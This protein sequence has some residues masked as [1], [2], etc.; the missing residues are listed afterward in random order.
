MKRRLVSFAL[1]CIMLL[2]PLILS[3]CGGETIPVDPPAKVYTIYTICGE[4][5]TQESIREVE[6]ALNR[7]TFYQLGYNVKLIMVTEDEYD[8]LIEQTLADVKA[9]EEAKKNKGKGKNSSEE[10]SDKGTSSNESSAV[11]TG[12]DYIALLENGEDYVLPNPRLDIFLVKGYDKYIDLVTRNLLAPLDDKLDSDAKLIKDY[13]F[14]SFLEAAKVTNSKG[15]R[16][17]YGIP[18][19]KGIGQYDYI[20][21]DKEY[22]DKYEID[23]DTMTNLWDLEYYLKIITENEPEVVPLGN[24]FDDPAVSY[25]FDDGFTAYI[26][27]GVT[28][29]STYTD[30]SVLDYFTLISRYRTMGYLQDA[31]DNRRW[32]VKFVR[33]TFEDI[34]KLE[35]ETGREYDYTIHSYPVATNEDLLA[36]LFCISA[37][38]VSSDLTAAAEIL[39]FI[40]TNV[41]AANLLLHGVQG[42]H[43]D[44]D[45]KNQVVRKANT[46]NME[47]SHTGNAFITYTYKGENPEKWQKLMIQNTDSLKTKELSASLGFAYYPVGIK[48]PNDANQI[49]YE[50]N[51]VN[52]IKDHT[53]KFYPKLING[54]LLNVSWQTIV[55]T[56]GPVVTE[57][58]TA[59][60]TARYKAELN[61]IV[62]AEKGEKYAKG[63]D[64]YNR[65]VELAY[66]NAVKNYNTTSN[67]NKIKK[68]VKNIEAAKPENQGLSD[69]EL[70]ALVNQICTEEFLL[71]EIKKTYASQIEDRKNRTVVD[72]VAQ[73]T[74]RDYDDYIKTEEYQA[75]LE[76]V[77]SSEEYLEEMLNA[78][79]ANVFESHYDLCLVEINKYLQELIV[80]EID[81]FF[82]EL[83]DDL[84]KEYKKFQQEYVSM[85]PF[86][87]D[88]ARS[89]PDYRIAIS[90]VVKKATKNRN[91]M[92]SALRSELYKMVTDELTQELG[93]DPLPE[94]V[95]NTVNERF[96]DEWIQNV[97]MET[98]AYN[99]NNQTEIKYTTEA[100]R[101]IVNDYI[102]ISQV[103]D[104]YDDVILGTFE[105]A[106][107]LVRTIDVDLSSGATQGGD[108]GDTS[109]ESEGEETGDTSGD[110]SGGGNG[111]GDSDPEEGIVDLDKTDLY[112]IIFKKRIEKQYYTYKPLPTA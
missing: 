12:D 10:T 37:Y 74:K 25:L 102:T 17:T 46:Y 58:L 38:T 76:A 79:G 7:L 91:S 19:N 51:Y 41:A 81:K 14:P 35:K 22:L 31:T 88:A 30:K 99:K 55:D 85:F 27:N 73:Y 104:M 5:T 34:E 9:Y 97:V 8:E 59:D 69:A 13:V 101:D 42:V 103:A 21:F 72:T 23:A 61:A 110:T 106:I 71:E 53:S 15:Q 26:K 96:T 62:L 39:N 11:F 45:E 105:K 87:D 6:L 40:E 107:G 36:N 67:K 29:N 80:E 2:S 75:R 65:I 64:L 60:I 50:P 33:G 49:I 56:I 1:V 66:E 24:V 78:T 18:M 32:A 108:N 112:P 44:L 111:G 68:E 109:D 4:G 48:H 63:T 83:N 98:F 47:V 43:Y 16:K 92:T 28:V 52:I 100:L 70:D 86:N 82:V 95:N 90:N 3:S 20:V 57:T 54:K 89:V 93:K 94:D 84:R 77:L